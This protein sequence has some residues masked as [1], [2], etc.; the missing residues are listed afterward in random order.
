M[1]RVAHRAGDRRW[2]DRVWCAGLIGGI[3]LHRPTVRALRNSATG[4]A[5]APTRARLAIAAKRHQKRRRAQHKGDADALNARVAE[6]ANAG[7]T[8]VIVM[9]FGLKTKAG[10]DP[11]VLEALAPA[12]A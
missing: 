10:L 2:V 12:A 8:R 11:R 5:H 4:A 3:G 6:Y 9:P 7:A 1:S